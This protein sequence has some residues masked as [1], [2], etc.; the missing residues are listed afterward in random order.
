MAGLTIAKSREIALPP[1]PQSIDKAIEVAQ[2][3]PDAMDYLVDSFE[4]T[5]ATWDK[6][7]RDASVSLFNK[8]KAKRDM[9]AMQSE[10]NGDP[11]AGVS[12]DAA[13]VHM[14][15]SLAAKAATL[16]QQT[17]NSPVRVDIAIDEK[18]STFVRGFS[19]NRQ[20]M[21]GTQEQHLDQMINSFAGIHQVIPKDSTFYQATAGRLKQEN[22]E[23]VKVNPAQMEQLITNREKGLAAFLE[24]YGLKVDS[25][26]IQNYPE[27][28]AQTAKETLVEKPAPAS[29]TLTQEET[30]D[31]LQR[32]GR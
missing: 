13:F 5:R 1:S 15:K 9:V 6:S 20:A 10:G 26:N 31:A 25:V 7:L 19:V 28:P 24:S 14:Q 32:P 27:A 16:L 11:W 2:Y 30:P 3:S 12:P 18:S 4:Q 8:I 21:D 17:V 29:P 22:D 23:P